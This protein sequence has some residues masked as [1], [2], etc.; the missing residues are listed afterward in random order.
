M[1]QGMKP[2]HMPNTPAPKNSLPPVSW[3][4]CARIKIG[5][6]VPRT[7]QPYDAVALRSAIQPPKGRLPFT[8][9]LPL[10]VVGLLLTTAT[11]ADAP[12]VQKKQANGITVFFRDSQ[13]SNIKELRITL[14]VEASLNQVMALLKDVDAFPEWIYGCVSSKTLAEPSSREVLYYSL[15]D[16]PWPLS[17]RDMVV[18]GQFYQDRATKTIHLTSTAKPEAHPRKSGI[19]RVEDSKIKWVIRPVNASTS[20][21]DYHLRSDPGGNL[22]DWAVNLALDAGPVKTMQALR[23]MLLKEKYRNPAVRY[24][25]DY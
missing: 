13:H 15:V 9:L 20:E 10:A 23:K 1:T 11:S 24:V 17:D 8:N 16:F 3:V 6:Q 25:T 5:F 2:I 12:W 7:A 4:S 21:I 22:P 18:R 19:V 14:R